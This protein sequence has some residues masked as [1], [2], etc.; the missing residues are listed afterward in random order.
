MPSYF[1]LIDGRIWQKMTCTDNE[2]S[3]DNFIFVSKLS[4][5]LGT[6]YGSFLGEWQ[7]WNHTLELSH[8][9]QEYTIMYFLQKDDIMLH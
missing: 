8:L 4:V 3:N 6:I 9:Y 1:G 7:K 5:V 2:N